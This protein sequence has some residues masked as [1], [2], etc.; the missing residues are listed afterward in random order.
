M[1]SPSHGTLGQVCARLDAARFE[2]GFRDWVQEAFVLTNGQVV[3]IDGKSVRGSHDWGLGLCRGPGQP[4]GPPRLPR[5][6]VP[7]IERAEHF[8][9][10]SHNDADMGGKDHGHI[11][12]RCCWVVGTSDYIA[13]STPTASGTTQPAWS[14]SSSNAT[15]VTGSRLTPAISSPAYPPRPSP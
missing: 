2:E 8:A 1:R 11:E 14:G 5:G 15:A 12:I 7:P 10:C 9:D 13:Y 6:N 4:L 3:P